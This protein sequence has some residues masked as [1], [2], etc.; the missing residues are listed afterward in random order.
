MLRILPFGA[1]P[2][3]NAAC[4]ITFATVNIVARLLPAEWHTRPIMPAPEAT[5]TAMPVIHRNI[6]CL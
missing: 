4:W 6:S 5:A 2:L 1:Y 3:T